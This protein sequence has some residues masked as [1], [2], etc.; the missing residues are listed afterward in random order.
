MNNKILFVSNK[1]LP[2][3][4]EELKN[5]FDIST[6]KN[7]LKAYKSVFVSTPDV[8][9]L[10]VSSIFETYHFSKLLEIFEDT[11]NIPLIL[12][13]GKNPIPTNIDFNTYHE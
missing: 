6:E 9:I 7:I 2:K 1:K 10:N 4:F 11:K 13:T 3:Q 8:I 12:M 5:D